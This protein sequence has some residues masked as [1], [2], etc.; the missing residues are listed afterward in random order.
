VAIVGGDLNNPHDKFVDLKRQRDLMS[1]PTKDQTSRFLAPLR[2]NLSI[3]LLHETQ[4]KVNVSRFMLRCASLQSIDTTILDADAFYC[5]NMERFAEEA[6][7]I[8]K[9]EVLVLPEQDFEVSSLVPL[10]SSKRQLLIVDDLNSLYSLASDTHKSQQLTILMKFLSHNARMNGSWAI[11]T[12]YRTEL[13]H[14][15]QSAMSQRSLTALGDLLID[16]DSHADSIKLRS[17]F[18]GHWTNGEFSL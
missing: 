3:L 8:S 9:G 2:G 16:T 12:A 1:I 11:A 14:N 17:S 5:T 10:L 4:A 7:S 13:D 6:Q 15:K 18:K